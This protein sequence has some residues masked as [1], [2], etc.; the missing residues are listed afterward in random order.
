MRVLFVSL[1]WGFWVELFIFRDPFGDPHFL[2]IINGSGRYLTSSEFEVSDALLFIKSDMYV[3][4]A[5]YTERLIWAFG[6]EYL[7]LLQTSVL[8]RGCRGTGLLFTP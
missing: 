2:G 8:G 1:A 3:K 6:R 4:R 7:L 5:T